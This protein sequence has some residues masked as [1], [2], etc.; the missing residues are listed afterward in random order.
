MTAFLVILDAALTLAAGAALTGLIR[1]HLTLMERG[2]IGV[3]TGVL[4]A[5]G[6]TYGLALLF[7]LSTATV[8][9]GPLVTLAGALAAS[10]LTVDPRSTWYASWV[11]SRDR[12][13]QHKP[14]FSIV[15][16][17]AGVVA[18]TAIFAHTVYTDAGGLEAG[19]P[20]VW[21]DWSQHLT[22]AASFA[23]GGN[24]PPINPLF[25]GTTLLYP[26]LPDFHAATLITLGLAPGLA[27]AIPGAVLMVVIGMLVV[28]LGHRL[29]LGTGAGVIA[30]LICFIGGGLGFIGVFADACTNHGFTATQCTLPVRR[31]A[32]R[33][34]AFDHRL[35]PA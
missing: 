4:V 3:V 33:H 35:D 21:A 25:S 23:V 29:G 22:T 12:W 24:I 20:T 16:L 7:G 1:T 32:S 19:Y 28:A 6:V 34:R 2:L 10:L 8:L 30:V 27:L 26:F 31:H 17:A 11:E 15:A 18:V 13:A 14:W 5:S 9:E